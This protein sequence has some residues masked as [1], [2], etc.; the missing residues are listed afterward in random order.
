MD[1]DKWSIDGEDE[2]NDDIFK[3]DEAIQRYLEN[4]D[5][6]VADFTGHR[7]IFRVEPGCITHSNIVDAEEIIRR[8]AVDFEYPFLGMDVMNDRIEVRIELS[9]NEAPLE[10]AERFQK[11]LERA[12]II[13]ELLYIGTLSKEQPKQ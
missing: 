3:H 5:A 12:G 8:T 6:V 2:V 10:S 4:P 7:F 1:N 13:T 11:R 9:V